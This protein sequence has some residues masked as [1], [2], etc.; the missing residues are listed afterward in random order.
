MRTNCRML[1]LA[2]AVAVIAASLLFFQA[3]IA[4]AV[5]KSRRNG[6]RG[7]AAI[8]P[9]GKK[10]FL[11]SNSIATENAALCV[12]CHSAC[13]NG[14]SH[15]GLSAKARPGY[16]VLP[17]NAEGRATCI[18]CHES[19]SQDASE[20]S[21]AHLRIS[22]LR[23]ELC[24]ACHLNETETGLRIEILSPLER[25]V[26]HEEHLALI[27]R[28][29]GLPESDL[30][31]RLNGAEF[32]LQVK[33]GEFSTWLKLQDGVNRIEVTLQECLL[34]KGEVFHGESSLGSYRLASSGH[35]TGNRAQCQE[36]HLKRNEIRDGV[37]G[38]APTLCYSCHDRIDGKRYVH[39]PLAVGDCL[40][41]HDPHGG[42]GAA[43]LRQE[44]KHL[45]GN[46]HAAR[47]SVATV[48]CNAAGKGCVDCHDPHQS[49]TR[50][51]LK[52]PQYTLREMQHFSERQE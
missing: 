44:E 26:V 29:S 4:N 6:A 51:L 42:Y 9:A 2:A 3:G 39:G 49:D 43:H 15:S 46:C 21:G 20:E 12:K 38:A 18:T 27:G 45:C 52:G 33:E 7:A 48:A 40:A 8:A 14:S 1:K 35:R 24:L 30:T 16:T 11:N 17:L 37:T 31:V 32:H 13:E 41:C 34:W 50:Y 25:A 5:Q 47:E 28:A 36:C 10:S 23:R 22:N 19:H